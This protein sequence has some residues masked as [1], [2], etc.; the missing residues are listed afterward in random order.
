[1]SSN[2]AAPATTHPRLAQPPR[3]LVQLEWN[4]N[5]LAAYAL[6]DSDVVVLAAGGQDAELHLSAHAPDA[7]DALWADP[8][9]QR[10][11]GSINNAVAFAPPGPGCA[12]PTLVVNNND[13]SVQLFDV[14]LRKGAGARLRLRTRVAFPTPVNHCAP[15]APGPAHR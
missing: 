12:E 15:P 11:G 4:P 3:T 2:L 1:V 10:I 5:S 9:G 14:A 8:P 13:A 6:P 7:A